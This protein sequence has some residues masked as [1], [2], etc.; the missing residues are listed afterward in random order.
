MKNTY[1]ARQAILNTNMET[2]GYELFFRDSPENKFP[3][4]DQ[5]VAS[6]K[7]IIQNHIYGD[8]QSLSMGKVAFINFTENSLIHKYPLMFSKDEIIIELMGHTTPTKNLLKIVN[9][10]H[11]KGYQIALSEYD[12]ATHWDE[13]FPLIDIIKINIEKINT[14]RIISALPR[15]KPHNIK[16]TAEKVET[17]YQKQTLAE[18]GFSYFQGYFYHEPEIVA[19]KK[20][21]SQKTLML[22]LLS[23]T[24]NTPIN[25]DEVAKIISHD[26]N[27]TIGL[28]K[29]VNNVAT[30]SRVEI[31]SLKQ[32]A[33]YLGDEKLCQFVAILALSNLT[34][35]SA[36]EVCKQALITGRMMSELSLNNSFESVSEF[37]FITGLLSE[38]EVLLGMPLKEIMKTMPLALKIEQALIKHTGTLGELLKLTTAYLSGSDKVTNELIGNH[39]LNK[40]T[41]QQ[42][43]VNAS[44]W[45]SD[46]GV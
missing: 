42:E 2:I 24:F 30:G 38:I 13:F 15:I 29:M 7:L 40:Q 19:D 26:V 17:K 45:C 5:D 4:I 18:I 25:Y 6:S 34:S 8:I 20:L 33:V 35:D 22:Q 14:K 36:E 39:N 37:A 16:L 21:T 3:E 12:L 1:I 23:E 28:L 27:L 32:A 43:F 10:Y 9:Y 31:K 41:L 11:K 46:V 44:Q